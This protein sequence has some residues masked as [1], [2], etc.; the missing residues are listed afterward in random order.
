MDKRILDQFNSELSHSS[1]HTRQIRAFYALK[2]LEFAD[3]RPF[4][5]WNKSLV[6]DFLEKM[7]GEDYSPGSIRF[8]YSVVKRVFDAAKTVHEAERTKLISGADPADPNAIADI[9]KAISLPGPQWDLGKRSAPRVNSE[10]VVK[11]ASTMEELKVVVTAAKAGVLIPAETAYLT[12]STVYGLRREELCRVR[13]EHLNFSDRTIYV[14]TAKGGEQR[15]QLL[16]DAVIPHLEG[17]D[18]SV[19]YSPYKMSELYLRIW[20]KAGLEPK[21]GGGWHSC[22]RLLDTE[23]VT[24]FGQLKTHIFLRWKLSTSSL[25]TERYFSQDP[26]AVDKEV[27]EGGHPVV[28]LWRDNEH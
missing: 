22:R 14:L 23:L 27:L 3:G 7:K 6:N 15:H 9:L 12:L 28:P 8:I 26:L 1:E 19:V 20:A 17:Y 11:P 5:E 25:M 21:E 4:T 2:F 13:Q 18:F 24:I 10:D 16:S